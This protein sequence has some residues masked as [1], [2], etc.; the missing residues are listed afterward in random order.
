MHQTDRL[1][2][3]PYIPADADELFA[4]LRDPETMRF[5]DIWPDLEF[6]IRKLETYELQRSTL[7]YSAWVIREQGNEAIIGWGGLYDDPFDTG[8]GPEVGYFFVPN[9]W[10]RGYATELVRYSLEFA[11]LQCALNRVRAFAH[12]MNLASNRVLEKCGFQKVEFIERMNRWLYEV[13]P[14]YQRKSLIQ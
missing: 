13:K 11:G 6:C 3:A 10:R 7:G 9:V 5:T 8:W 2:L 4:F 1:A 14:I 12:P